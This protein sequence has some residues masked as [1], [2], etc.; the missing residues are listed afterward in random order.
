MAID[1]D[2]K[3]RQMA[4][5]SKYQR[6]YTHLCG[7]TDQEWKASFDEIESIIGFGLP[8]SARL[9][10]PWWANQKGGGGH[11]QALAWTMAGWETAEI[12]LESETLMLRRRNSDSVD[13]VSLDEVWPAR[14]VGKWPEGLSTSREDL[15]AER[16]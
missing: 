13:P 8:A 6:L 5:R 12:D 3:Y 2:Q 9:H 11:S 10:K 4:V 16:M 14:S 1:R 7:L 15:C